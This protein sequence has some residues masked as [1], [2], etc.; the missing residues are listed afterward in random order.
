MARNAN[1]KLSGANQELITGR[2]FITLLDF[3]ETSGSAAGLVTLFDGNSTAGQSLGTYS[4][5]EGDTFAVA[6]D[7]RGLAYE[8]GIYVDVNSTAIAGMIA[9]LQ[10]ESEAEWQAILGYLGS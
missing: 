1:L 10:C 7:R 8:R 4:I 3:A 6:L 9:V 2:G 5:I